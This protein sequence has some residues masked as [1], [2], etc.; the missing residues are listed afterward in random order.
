[1]LTLPLDPAP[2]LLTLPLSR[3]RLGLAPPNPPLN[4]TLLLLTLPL[5]SA[6]T[7]LSLP[8]S[9]DILGLESPPPPTPPLLARPPGES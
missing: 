5:D 3:D 7:L 6:P 2:T 9:L 4:P 1:L 8:L